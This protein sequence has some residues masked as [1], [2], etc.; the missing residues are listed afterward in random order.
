[1]LYRTGEKVS[2]KY[3]FILCP[4]SSGSTLLW[5]ILQTS[6]HVS[7]FQYE[8]KR[9][10]RSILAA[11]DRWNPAKVIPWDRVEAKWSEHWDFKKPVL[12]EKSPPHLIRAEQLAAHFHDSYFIV[13]IRNPYA[14]CEGVK[15]RWLP[16]TSY[17]NLARFW[18]I[19]ASYLIDSIKGLKNTMYLTYEELTDHPDR[20]CRRLVDFVPELGALHLDRKFDVFEKS[21]GVTNLNDRQINSLSAD[22]LFEINMALKRYP[23]FLKF[24]NYP[25]IEPKGTVTFKMWKRAFINIRSL[26]HLPGPVRWQNWRKL[27]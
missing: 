5:K 13:M 4:P 14:F 16:G 3:L 22:I 17:F 8:G 20:I 24:F 15:R 2:H 21:M 18:L 1:M 9:L 12:L 11:E 23:E 10:A 26:G 7:A 6:P 19:C 25:Y 27:R